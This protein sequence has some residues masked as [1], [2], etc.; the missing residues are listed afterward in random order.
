MLVLC[1]MTL[2]D[3]RSFVTEHHRHHR[4]PQGGLFA[5]GVCDDSE[6][7]GV[8]IVGRPVARTGGHPKRAATP[9]PFAELLVSMARSGVQGGQNRT[10]G[11]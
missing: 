10:A 8:A 9:A 1:P 11:L 4:A 2:R 3:A 6:V 5:V 7:R